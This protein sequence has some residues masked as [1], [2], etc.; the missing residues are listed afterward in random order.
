[1]GQCVLILFLTLQGQEHIWYL[2]SGCSRHMTGFKSLLDDYVKKDGPAVTYGDNSQGQTK[3]FGTIKCKTVEF[4]NVS[5]VKGLRHNLV[6]I[7]QL[8]DADYEVHFNKKEGKVID[9]KK[10]P[11]LTA[12]RR[13]DIYVL[14]MF[15]A[16]KSLR[17]CFFSRAQSHMNWLWHKRLSHLNFKT[18]SKISNDQLVRGMPRMKSKRQ[19]HYRD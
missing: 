19:I 18:L 12:N 16:D 13:D 15:S 5:Y 17:R 6:S 10:V 2:D 9:S 14:D 8:C 3:G 7:S 1:M 4:R 11:V